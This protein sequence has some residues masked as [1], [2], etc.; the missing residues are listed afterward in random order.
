MKSFDS[1]TYR[2][3]K[4]LAA[5]PLLTLAHQAPALDEARIE[6]R[7]EEVHNELGIDGEGVIVCILDRGLDWK[8][9]DFR[10]EDGSTRIKYILDFTNNRGSGDI[11]TEEEINEALI[12]NTELLLT[13]GGVS[14]DAVGHDTTTTGI[15]A[16]N[17]RDSDGIYRGMA[18][19]ATLI[20]IKITSDGVPAHDD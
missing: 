13:G 15:A 16:G 3:I 12:N 18:P 11:F 5:I 7:V 2:A 10:N 6:T 9:N 19:K 1:L 14:R 4:L 20:I 8:S 17:G